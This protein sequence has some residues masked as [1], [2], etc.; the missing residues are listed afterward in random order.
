M[1]EFVGAPCETTRLGPALAH[2]QEGGTAVK[3]GKAK[4]ALL[5][6][7]GGV[8]CLGAY[9]S[10]SYTLSPAAVD[11][12]GGH[13]ESSGYQLDC[14]IGGPVVATSGAA[15]SASYKLE[16]N[17]V[18]MLAESDA[19][20]GVDDGGGCASGGSSLA[21]LLPLALPA[22]AARRRRQIV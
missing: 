3:P 2:R 5:V 11:S 1:G 13:A 17:A 14:S 9:V 6:V 7:A 18:G 15:S 21:W 20:G 22:L 4:V 19:G 10:A 8:L 12:G 16:V